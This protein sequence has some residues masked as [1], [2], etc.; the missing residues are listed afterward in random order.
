LE[1]IEVFQLIPEIEKREIRRSSYASIIYSELRNGLVHEYELF[2]NLASHGW[3]GKENQLCYINFLIFPEEQDVSDV[4]KRC[5]ISEEKARDALS[6]TERRLYFP[7]SFIRNLIKGTA[8]SVFNYWESAQE[9]TKPE[10]ASWWIT[11][12]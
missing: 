12:S 5:G 9:F 7:Y 1:E 10:P 4:D 8:E 11:S 6:R 2:P 3:P